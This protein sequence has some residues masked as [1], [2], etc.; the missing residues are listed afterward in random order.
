M[1][2]RIGGDS[3]DGTNLRAV[4]GSTEPPAGACAP[5]NGSP[6][7]QVTVAGFA[8]SPSTVTARVGEVVGWTNQDSA[9]HA[10]GLDANDS[11]RTPNLG[12]GDVGTLVFSEPGTYPY[13]CRIHPDMRGTIEIEG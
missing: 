13:H 7:A 3:D 12:A 11:C 9:P 4:V 1:Q 2:R 6:V 10:V 8:F 5:G